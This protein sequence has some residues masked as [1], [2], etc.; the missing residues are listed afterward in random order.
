[1]QN[2]MI[3]MRDGVK[4]ESTVILPPGQG[5][6][7]VVL[8]RMAYN[9][10]NCTTVDYARRGLALVIQD[11]RG[12][13]GSQ[14]DWFP[15]VNEPQ[16]GLDTLDWILAQPWCDGHIGMTGDSYLAHVQICLAPA[17]GQETHGHQP[18]VHGRRPLATRLLRRRRPQP[19][20]HVELAV[21]RG[22]LAH[23]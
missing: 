21:L 20:S 9:R 12:R 16:D 11:V 22:R 10:A 8:I 23:L 3:P 15:F 17:G 2:V 14:G 19:G 4:L 18:A 7:P 1:M 5:R 6:F 13:Y